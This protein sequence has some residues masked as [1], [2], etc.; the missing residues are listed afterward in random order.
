MI[1]WLAPRAVLVLLVLSAGACDEKPAKIP[2]PQEATADAVAEFCGMTMAEHPGPKGQIF[3]TGR[4]T[5]LW[6]ASVHDAF[7]FVMLP[8]TPKNT[9]AI[10][11]NDM[12]KAKDWDHPEAGTWID[13]RRAIFVIGSG[14]HGGMGEDEAV[15]FLNEAAAHAFAEENGG[16][17][18]RF[19]EMPRSYILPNGDGPVSEEQHAE[20]DHQGHDH[21]AHDHHPEPG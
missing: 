16:T 17:L 6:F 2:T 20:H 12:G 1:R 5:P 10:Y 15:P 3:L 13:A 11:V 19:A 8:E 18:V 14:R 21:H 7:A 9:A 4:E